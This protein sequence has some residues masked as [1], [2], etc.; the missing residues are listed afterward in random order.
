MS[1][2]TVEISHLAAY[3]PDTEPQFQVTEEAKYLGL[4]GYFPVVTV[5]EGAA[6]ISSFELCNLIAVNIW[7]SSPEHL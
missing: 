7:P 6:H 2:N 3:K 1:G 4:F 5:P